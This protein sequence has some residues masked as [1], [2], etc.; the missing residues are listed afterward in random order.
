MFGKKYSV[1]DNL[2]IMTGNGIRRL[3]ACA[4]LRLSQRLLRR[5]CHHLQDQ[6]RAASSTHALPARLKVEDDMY[7]ATLPFFP[8]VKQ[9]YD[10]EKISP[11]R[12]DH[13]AALSRN[14]CLCRLQRLHQGLHAGILTSC[15]TSH[16]L[17]EASSTS[18]AELS[19]DCVMCGVCSSRCPAGISH[20][21]VA[22]L[23]RRLNGKYLAPELR[24]ILRSSVREIKNGTFDGAHRG[25]YA[26]AYRGDEGAVQ[27][28]ARSKSK[29]ASRICINEQM[30]ESTEKGRG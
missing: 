2:T 11:D 13:D 21:Q 29:E 18:A 9:V 7:I 24:V 19:F 5:L 1:P 10:I 20:P 17:R 12:A 8:L 14:L 16:T 27:Q 15:S 25:S 22:M 6:G 28:S 4:R 30:Y 26:E 3:S 23:A